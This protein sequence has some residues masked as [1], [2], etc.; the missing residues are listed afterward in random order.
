MKHEQ[1]QVGDIWN[2]ERLEKS[3]AAGGGRN[4]EQLLEG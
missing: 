3:V 2:R 1:L 4:L